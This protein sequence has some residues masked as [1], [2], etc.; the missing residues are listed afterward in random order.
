MNL[1]T[2]NIHE[3]FA[4]IFPKFETSSMSSEIWKF[5]L[6]FIVLPGMEKTNVYVY[7]IFLLPKLKYNATFMKTF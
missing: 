2:L 6:P 3:L 4:A 1:W 5:P 7:N